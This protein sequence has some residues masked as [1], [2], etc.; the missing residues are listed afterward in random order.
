MPI[1]ETKQAAEELA[2]F[3]AFLTAH[4]NFAATVA[5]THQPEAEFPD[6]TVRLHDGNRIDFELAQWLD[7]NQMGQAKRREQ[8]A[9]AITDAIGEQGENCSQYFNFVLLFPQPH[10]PRF[11]QADAKGFRADIWTLIGEI[12]R[13]W[14]EERF[15]HSPQGCQLNRFDA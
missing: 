2:V 3:T 1:R 12:E 11:A 10:F 5:A 4:P 7:P 15:W 9:D 8:L 14:P 6:I 13:R